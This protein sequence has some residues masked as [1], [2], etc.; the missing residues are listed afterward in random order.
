MRPLTIEQITHV[1][2]L[3]QVLP[4]GSTAFTPKLLAGLVSSVID[5]DE[6]LV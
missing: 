1:S 3:G 6:D 5:P 4:A 2:D